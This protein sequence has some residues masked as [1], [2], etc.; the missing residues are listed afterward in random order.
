M[1]SSLQSI[2]RQQ[3]IETEHVTKAAQEPDPMKRL[4]AWLIN[5]L[6]SERGISELEARRQIER[7]SIRLIEI[8]EGGYRVYYRESTNP[9]I[10]VVRLK[11]QESGFDGLGAD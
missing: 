2:T 10:D 1:T 7:S 9:S 3:Q 11:P 4:S 8:P 6:I 5:A